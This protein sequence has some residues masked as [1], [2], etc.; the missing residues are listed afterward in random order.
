[1][2]AR[3]LST[4][5]PPRTAMRQSPINTSQHSL[6][7]STKNKRL[8]IIAED[9]DV[10]SVPQRPN[11]VHHRPHNSRWNIGDPPRHSFENSP[12]AYSV[13]SLTKPRSDKLRDMKNNK[14]IVGRGGWRRILAF[15]LLVIATIVALV[16]GLVVGL[17]RRHHGQRY[18]IPFVKC[19]G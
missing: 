16:V 17:R 6:S 12:P 1:M 9:G 8:S 13:W 11:R 18:S 15:A 7:L 2:S 5:S 10:P 19:Q 14:F 4:M 3:R